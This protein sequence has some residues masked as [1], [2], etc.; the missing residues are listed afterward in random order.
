ME[1]LFEEFSPKTL[2][3]WNEKII[4]DLKGKDYENLIWESP[5]N[6]KIAPVYNRESINKLKGDTT[7][8]H[9]N[10]EIEQT[11]NDPTNKKVL[12]CLNSGASALLLKGIPAQD[13]ETVLK[14]VLLQ[15]IQTSLQST[16]IESSL[17]AFI[18]LIEK[19]NL[20][21]NSIKGSLHYD[22][23]MESLKKG[24]IHADLWSEFKSVQEKVNSLGAYKSICIQGQEYHNAGASATQELAFTLAQLSEYFANNSDL[25]ADKIRVSLGVSTNYFFEIAKFRALRILWSQI[26]KAYKKEETTLD[27]RAETGLRTSTV[28][29]PYVNML[30]TTSQCMSAALGG[31]NTIN[32]NS[33]NAAYKKDDDFGQRMA[34]N[35]SLILKEESYFNKVNDPSAGSYYIEHLTNELSQNAW[36]LFQKIEAQG[37]WIEGVKTNSIQEMIAQNAALQEEDLNHGKTQLLGTNLYP[38]TDEEMSSKMERSAQNDFVEGNDFKALNTKRLSALMDVERLAKEENHA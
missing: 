13:M 26:L 25:K 38:N 17:D 32:V 5:E 18:K 8:H 4:S 12:T 35:I 10:W 36:K 9:S 2:K 23:L 15:H 30:R 16:S 31:A 37:G 6:I 28:F 20:D 14:D 11:L 19:R 34:K 33:F 27:L 29:D 24:S 1:K 7:H 21:K 3:E 22:P